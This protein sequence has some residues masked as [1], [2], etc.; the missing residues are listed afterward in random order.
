VAAAA[1][2]DAVAEAQDRVR[3]EVEVGHEARG[4]GDLLADDAVGAEMDPGLAEDRAEREGES[5]TC[6]HGAEAVPAGVLGGDGGR[7]LQPGPARVDGALREAPP[8]G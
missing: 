5:G 8:P 7:P 1:Q 2:D 3:A 6:S 4:E